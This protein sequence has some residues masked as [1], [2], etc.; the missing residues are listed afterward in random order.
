MTKTDGIDIEKGHA[1]PLS[2]GGALELKDDADEPPDTRPPLPIPDRLKRRDYA[3]SRVLTAGSEPHLPQATDGL[4]ARM[5]PLHVQRSQSLPG[6]RRKPSSG[7]H[8]RP[9]AAAAVK[10]APLFQ[11]VLTPVKPLKAPPTWKRSAV[12]TL[13]YSWLSVLLIFLPISWALHFATSNDTAI[14]VT[15]GLAIIPLAGL[16]GFATE[17]IALRVGDTFGALLNCTFGNTVR[18][19]V[20]CLG[21]G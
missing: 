9:S 6:M 8:L 14:F 4:R 13:K 17:E 15:S 1:L 19:F 5:V 16:L 12:N 18:R 20:A 7:Q 11:G 3:T 10:P 21:L 2:T